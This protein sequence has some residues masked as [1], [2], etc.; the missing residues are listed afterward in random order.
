MG[1]IEDEIFVAGM[2]GRGRESYKQII[3]ITVVHNLDNT[4]S[5]MT[6]H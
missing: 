6:S 3:M 1:N 2:C 4:T 5:L